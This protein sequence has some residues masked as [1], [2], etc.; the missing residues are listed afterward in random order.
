LTD[1]TTR[2]SEVGAD[3]DAALD[4]LEQ[5]VEGNG[6]GEPVSASNLK[7]GAGLLIATLVSFV[8][9]GAASYG[10]YQFYLVDQQTTE[11]VNTIAAVEQSIQDIQSNQNSVA[12][13]L[14]RFSAQQSAEVAGMQEKLDA[15]LAE[16]RASAGTSSQDWILAEVEYLLRLANQRIMI[17]KE[18]SGAIAL[19]QSADTIIV[20]ADNISAL[21]VREAIAAD[22]ASLKSLQRL[23]IEGTYVALGA[24]IGQV[25]ELVGRELAFSV[26]RIDEAE[27]EEGEADADRSWDQKLLA[28][29]K[30]IGD[31]LYAL[32]DYRSG[33]ERVTPILPPTEEYYLEQNLVFKLEHAQLA[34]LRGNQTAYDQSVLDSIEWVRTH[35]D[36]QHGVTRNVLSTLDEISH[37]KV[38]QTIPDISGSLNVIRK[39]LAEFHLVAEKSSQQQQE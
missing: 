15:G 24:V 17:E 18:V 22:I 37:A 19:L 14:E 27:T 13:E 9:I 11:L 33:T 36:Q 2:S 23:D 10:V 4:K 35:F 5:K 7:L 29:T 6:K 25:N 20:Q 32:V 34:L 38:E 26:K 39:Y 12:A 21:P 30:L 1:Q 8:A 28:A 3:L 31:K 16:F